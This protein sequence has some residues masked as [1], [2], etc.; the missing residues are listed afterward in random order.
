MKHNFQVGDLIITK[1]YTNCNKK[2]PVVISQ[3]H[4]VDT[5]DSWSVESITLMYSDSHTTRLPVTAIHSFLEEPIKRNRWYHH[6]VVR[7]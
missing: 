7:E 3:I 5:F 6:P 1:D 2:I 4:P